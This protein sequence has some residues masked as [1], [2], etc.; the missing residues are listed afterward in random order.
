[1]VSGGNV[2]FMFYNTKKN[3]T[4]YHSWLYNK[5]T[6]TGLKYYMKP[7]QMMKLL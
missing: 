5:F 4:I 3:D 2:K 6:K 7:V 1:M